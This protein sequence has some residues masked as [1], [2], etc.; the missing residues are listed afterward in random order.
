MGRYLTGT[1]ESAKAPGAR[2][3]TGPL[4][5]CEVGLDEK[6]GAVCSCCL[7]AERDPIEAN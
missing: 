6:V 7:A 4:P 3:C 5:V 1:T 2:F